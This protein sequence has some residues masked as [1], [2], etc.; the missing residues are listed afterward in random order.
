MDIRPLITTTIDSIHNVEDSKEVVS[1]LTVVIKTLESENRQELIPTFLSGFN[2][3][4]KDVN[5]KIITVYTPV[6]ISEK[7]LKELVIKGSKQFK[8]ENNDVIIEQIID[9]NIMGGI[10]LKYA[11]KEIDLTTNKKIKVIKK[12]I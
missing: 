4:L 5:K 11:D 9:T 10:I 8:I 3:M 1:A 7:N 12:S 2:D 6:K